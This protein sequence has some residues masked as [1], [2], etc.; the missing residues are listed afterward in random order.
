MN[1]K[2]I[3]MAG[4]ITGMLFVI[5]D[6]AAAIL[7]APLYAPYYA[8]PIWNL[9]PNLMFGIL[10]NII[11]GFLLV[12]IYSVIY[13]GLPEEGVIKGLNYGIIV[14]TFRVLMPFFSAIVMYNIPFQLN[15]IGLISGF[16]EIVVLCSLLGIIYEKV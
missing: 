2:K 9:E 6:M 14:G 10:F 4:L 12:G 7:A 8:L 11:N 1:A 16:A 3:L 5:I 15:M 13:K